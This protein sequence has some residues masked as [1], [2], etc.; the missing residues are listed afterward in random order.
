MP[1]GSHKTRL[2][3][4]PSAPSPLARGN[5]RAGDVIAATPPTGDMGL[6]PP[7]HASH[8]V[9]PQPASNLHRH[10]QFAVAPIKRKLL[11]FKNCSVKK[12]VS[13]GTRRPKGLGWR[14][15]ARLRGLGLMFALLLL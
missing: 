4:R 8:L 9:V 10:R 12:H 13:P 6:S 3:P 1:F 7:A 15:K 14:D 5:G 2:W 11:F